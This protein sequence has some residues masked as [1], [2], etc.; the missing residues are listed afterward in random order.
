M[1]SDARFEDGDER[2]LRLVAFDAEDL[3]ILSAA[4][5]DSVFPI[6]EMRWQKSP[7]RFGVLLNRFR[8]ESTEAAKRKGRP[9]ERV[10]SVL[11]VD[12]VARVSTQGID[13]TDRETVLSL[14]SVTW[15]PGTDGSG[16]ILLTFAGDGAVAIE[17]ETLE[18]T[19][20]DVTR[21]YEA[22][23]GHVPDHGD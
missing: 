12:N 7:R 19:L 11:A 3:N 5:Q 1:I 22:V 20:R 13:Q 17:A 21:P 14:L 4:V 2:P 18:V 16:R 10:Q 8:W 6:T 23:S 15:E 9:V